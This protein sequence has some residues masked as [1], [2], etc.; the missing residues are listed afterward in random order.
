MGFLHRQTH[1]ENVAPAVKPETDWKAEARKWEARA[2]E[3]SKAAARLAEI[4]EA[5]KS[6]EQKAAERLAAAEKRAAEL[7]IKA[8]KAEIAAAT[9]VPSNLLIGNTEDELRTFAQAVLDFRG[10][11]QTGPYVPA[12]GNSPSALPLNGDGIEDALRRSLGIQ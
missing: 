12:E 1:A 10:Q 3:N 6:E 2:K 9:G 5:Q 4:E 7:E 11:V 8:L